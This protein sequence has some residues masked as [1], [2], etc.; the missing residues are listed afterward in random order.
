V[1]IRGSRVEVGEI[2]VVLNQHS[3]VREVAVVARENRAAENQLVAYVVLRQQGTTTVNDLRSFMKAKLPDYM[4]P[5]A[6]VLLDIL[7][8]T[9][10]GKVDRRALPEL[11]PRRPELE[12]AFVAPQNDFENSIATVWRDALHLEKVGIHDN[13][14]DLGGHSLLLVQVHSRVQRLVDRD[15][16]LIEMFEHPTV[17][18][19]ATHLGQETRHSLQ[20]NQNHI[21]NKIDSKSRITRQRLQRQRLS[22]GE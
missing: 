20:E 21:Q 22:H 18:S 3:A 10:N 7:P 19:L 5:A 9:P 17:H 6:F 11:D 1:K 4:I 15:L 2:E 8:I 13:F 14:F 16:S 12:Q